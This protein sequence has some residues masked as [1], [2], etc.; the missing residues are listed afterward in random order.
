MISGV[1]SGS[2]QQQHLA[3]RTVGIP[4]DG[5]AWIVPHPPR[6]FLK[7]INHVTLPPW[8][9]PDKE[10]HI[11]SPSITHTQMVACHLG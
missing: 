8:I 2:I 7:T 4:G 1:W 11:H 3:P 9:V 6:C 5:L 10:D